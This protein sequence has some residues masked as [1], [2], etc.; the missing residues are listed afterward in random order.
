MIGRLGV[1]LAFFTIIFATPA[2]SQNSTVSCWDEIPATSSLSWKPCYT[3]FTCANLQVPLDHEDAS[4]GT[5]NIAL[6]RWETPNQPAMGD[7][8]LNPGGPGSSGVGWLLRGKNRLVNLL[9][10]SY[11][12][13]G[14]DPRGVNNSGPSVDC[15]PGQ[16]FVREY[17]YSLLNTNYDPAN[18]QEVRNFW[19]AAGG[20]GDWCAQTLNQT[21]RYVN[22]PATARDMLTYAEALAESRGEPK[23][24]AKLNYYGVSYGSTL[25]T[26][27]A[28]LFPERVGRMIIS[29]VVDA[30]E[31]YGGTWMHSLRQADATMTKFFELCYE[32]RSAC[33]FFK[34]DSSAQDMQERFD[35]LIADLKR[36]PISVSDPRFLQFPKVIKWADVMYGV[37]LAVYNPSSFPTTAGILAQLEQ[38]NATSMIKLTSELDIP[39]GI[40]PPSDCSEPSVKYGEVGTR[41]IV[42]CNDQ[43]GSYNISSFEKMQQHISYLDNVSRYLGSIWSG[44]IP[45]YC[46]KHAFVPPESQIFP[47]Y[48]ETQTANPLL[49]AENTLDPIS[50]FAEKMANFYTGSVILKQDAVGHGTTAAVSNCTSAHFSNFM[51]TG[52]LPAA[53]TICDI[54]DP[55]PFLVGISEGGNR[56]VERRGLPFLH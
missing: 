52:K 31:H 27:F 26:T 38:R 48:K 4:A 43:H 49:F 50:S 3:D 47:G 20:Y 39:K 23:D 35:A 28:S 34:N 7:I 41:N 24:E 15:F 5:T 33:A 30:E 22:T 44:T 21:A 37:L 46:R 1:P 12:L 36:E 16:P 25:G 29:G 51:Q 18:E 40:M 42:G 10:T 9:G 17:Y 8:I 11:N 55:N 32:A 45:V 19:T 56:S 2:L 13:V 54:Q 6:L 14:M 53:G